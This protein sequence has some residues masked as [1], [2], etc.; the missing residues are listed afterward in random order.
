MTTIQFQTRKTTANFKLKSHCVTVFRI[1][2]IDK[3][4]LQKGKI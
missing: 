1:V 4:G 2:T 3:E